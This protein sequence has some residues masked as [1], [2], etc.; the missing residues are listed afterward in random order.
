MSEVLWRMSIFSFE[1]LGLEKLLATAL[2]NNTIARTLLEQVG[3]SA[4]ASQ[5]DNQNITLEL[6]RH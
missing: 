5:T 4:V 6:N 1:E 3:F 2:K